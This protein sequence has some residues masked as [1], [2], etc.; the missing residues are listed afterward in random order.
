MFDICCV[1]YR[2]KDTDFFCVGRRGSI[3]VLRQFMD[4][5]TSD[6]SIRAFWNHVEAGGIYTFAK[7]KG[8]LSFLGCRKLNKVLRENG[9]LLDMRQFSEAAFLSDP[10]GY[11]EGF[12]VTNALGVP[13]RI[14]DYWRERFPE[15]P[16]AIIL[17]KKQEE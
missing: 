8:F 11:V 3:N 9:L 15:L 4:N 12:G 5:H 17:R 2:F 6:F 10:F 1:L 14:S 16:E 7:P 13:L